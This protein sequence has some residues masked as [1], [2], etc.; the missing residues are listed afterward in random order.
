[1]GSVLVVAVLAIAVIGLWEGFKFCWRRKEARLRAMRTKAN[2]TIHQKLNK[3]ELKELQRILSLDPEELT[4]DQKFRLVE[5][6]T[7]FEATM[8]PNTSPVP[9]IPGEMA[10]SSSGRNKQ[11]TTK[12][13]G[14]QATPAFERVH[15]PPAPEVRVEMYAGPFIKCQGEMCFTCILHAGV[16]AT[17][18]E[19]RMYSSAGVAQKMP[20]G[21]SIIGGKESRNAQVSVTLPY[22]WCQGGVQSYSIPHEHW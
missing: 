4:V 19:L 8:P 22:R 7:R 3:T 9:T 2:K 6:R 10:S 5:L 18:V 14:V 11:P 16:Y 21:A 15:P 20:G 13:Q 1:M 12:D 17:L